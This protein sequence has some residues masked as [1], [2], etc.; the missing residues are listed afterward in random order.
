MPE[1]KRIFISYARKDGA[2]LAKRLMMDLES[3]G[4]KP[5][6]DAPEIAG[7]DSWT[8]DIEGGID[9]SDAVIALITPG[10]YASRICRAEQMRALRKDKLVIPLLA[11]TASDIPLYLETCNYRD[12]TGSVSYEK[13][14]QI[15]LEDLGECRG[16]ASLKPEYRSTYVTAPPLPLNFVARPDEQHT[17]R[18]FVMVS[19]DGTGVALTALEGMGGIGKTLLAQSLCHDE[20]IQQAFPDGVLWVT[21]GQK[22]VHSLRDR[23][24][25]IRS[26]L[27]D[28][29]GQTE[30]ELACIN[31][32]RSLLRDKT[33]LLVVDDVWRVTDIEPFLVESARSCVLFTTR[34]TSIAASLGA[35]ECRADLLS[36]QK[37]REILARY[38]GVTFGEL[39]REA[40]L[41]IEQC[42][43]LPLALAMVGAMLRGKPPVFWQRVLTLLHKADLSKIRTQ[44]PNYPH[45]DL[46]KCI[47]VGV[48]ALEPQQRERYLA[49]VVLP[50]DIAVTPAVQQA[51][52]NADP[53]DAIDTAEQLIGL[54]LARREG[55]GI[56][57]HDMQFD[58]I[59]AQFPNREALDL[60]HSAVRLSAHITNRDPNQFVSQMLGRLQPP[61]KDLDEIRQFTERIAKGARPPWFRPLSASLAAAGGPLVSTLRGHKAMVLDAAVTPDGRRVVSASG[62]NTLIVWDLE[63]GKGKQG[64]RGHNGYVTS[65]V[66]TPDGR[67]AISGSLDATVRVWN[68][69]DG[70][71]VSVLRGHA[72]PIEALSVTPDGKLAISASDDNNLKVWDLV[73]GVQCC[74]LIGHSDGVTDVK[75]TPDGR[76][77]VSTSKDKTLIVWDLEHGAERHT[78][79]TRGWHTGKTLTMPDGRQATYYG[80]DGV[81]KLMDGATRTTLQSL[82][83]HCG[84]VWCVALTC[85]GRA[86]SASHDGTLRVW[87]LDS[88]GE[89]QVL[90]GHTHR[91]TV[92][93]TTADGRHAISGSLDKTVRVWD[94]GTGK[95]LATLVG[96]AFD[97]FFVASIDNGRRV[98]SASSDNTLK[99]WDIENGTELGTLR[100]HT[101]QVRAL[102]LTPDGRG[103][104]SASND[105]TLRVWDLSLVASQQPWGGHFS[106]VNAVA[107]TADGLLALTASGDQIGTKACDNSVK[108]WDVARAVE[109]KTLEGHRD[110][111]W[112]IATTRDGHRAV[113]GAGDHD[114]KVWN[115]DSG[116]EIG[117]LHGHTKVVWHVEMTR[118]GQTAVSASADH[119]LMVWDLEHT[120]AR[121][122]LLGHTDGV[123]KVAIS[124]DG[125]RAV[126]ASNDHTVRVW[127]L[128]AGTEL[129]VSRTHTASSFAL[130]ITPDDTRVISGDADGIVKVWSLVDG[131]EHFILRGHSGPV[132]DIA[133]SPDCRL[134]VSASG[135]ATLR[136][137]SLSTGRL[138]RTLRGHTEYVTKVALVESGRVVS[139]SLDNTVRLWDLETGSMLAVFMGESGIRSLAV[140]RAGNVVAGEESG[141]VHFL[142][143]QGS[144]V[145]SLTRSRAS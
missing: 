61:K 4:F 62:D 36:L 136:V 7:G 37:S 88:G 111:V 116:V 46:L 26:A 99:V 49:L 5:W 108:L 3:Q 66:V 35:R 75:I 17:L 12:F 92:V 95:S 74:T 50:Q 115:L 14:F 13:Q 96:H 126:S 28:Q 110:Y 43:R 55:E 48:D 33:V 57:L 91:V 132:T 145:Q 82:A 133:V 130:A 86:V 67:L 112:T 142:S 2:E 58:Y 72:G 131:N 83:G 56:R 25:E 122:V 41:L 31:R 144:T 79:G 15:L 127:D 89:Q 68:L 94:L 109:L 100:A 65:V 44:F 38:S 73:R 113:S 129:R 39:P 128:D 70:R 11:K 106:P 143:I 102:A 104:I 30:S 107:V 98:L 121:H 52:W 123:N 21:A 85:D 54:S 93:V 77:A 141:R 29:H 120:T 76:Y 118:D 18:Q 24:N 137:W 40:E 53:D 45:A 71:E 8:D 138:N 59:R 78:L 60:I 105:G 34:D 80:S 84:T 27:N 47:Q 22:P 139:S 10:S 97:V 1:G 87:D 32:Y 81:L 51:L 103:A 6:L 124:S 64:L 42:G 114:L 16:G 63:S 20:A 101:E 69:E 90:R 140:T 9:D 23:I 125:C 119:T 135:D 134:A 117:T 19:T